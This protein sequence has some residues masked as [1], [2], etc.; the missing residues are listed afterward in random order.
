MR[1]GSLGERIGLSFFRDVPATPGV[2]FLFGD[3]DELLY[4]GKAKNLRTRLLSYARAERGRS[5]TRLVRL[6]SVVRSIRWEEHRTASEAAARETNLIRALRPPF[7]EALT[8]RCEYLFISMTPAGPH[9]VRLNMSPRACGTSAYGCFPYASRVP[10][11]FPALVR[12]LHHAQGKTPPSRIVRAAG[13]HVPLGDDLREAL[14]LFLSG[15]SPR[16]LSLVEERLQGGEEF[17]LRAARRDVEVVRTFYADG[18][19][20]VRRLRLRHELIAGAGPVSAELMN[21]W[22]GAELRTSMGARVGSRDGLEARILEMSASGVSPKKVAA[23]LNAE[24]VQRRG[25]TGRWTMWDVERVLRAH[26]W[27][28]RAR[29]G[30]P[31]PR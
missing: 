10:E 7:N 13:C 26:H 16:L 18:P 23:T 1:A 29:A 28:V 12:L 8:D 30:A 6:T 27:S 5:P 17:T 14:H 21:E 24:R 22:M 3:G 20:A 15:R 25:G 4:V 19:R 2:Y 31:V 11:V 9:R